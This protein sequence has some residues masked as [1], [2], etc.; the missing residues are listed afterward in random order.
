M[1]ILHQYHKASRLNA[2]TTMCRSEK[3]KWGNIFK[4]AGN[5][6]VLHVS[7]AVWGLGGIAVVKEY[8]IIMLKYIGKVCRLY[9][10]HPRI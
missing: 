9:F 7:S 4:M 1:S 10:V 6:F 3:W 5:G 8:E 2:C